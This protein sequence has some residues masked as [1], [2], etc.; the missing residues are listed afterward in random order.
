MSVYYSGGRRHTVIVCFRFAPSCLRVKPLHCGFTH[1]GCVFSFESLSH[2]WDLGGEETT[3]RSLFS[4]VRVPRGF[5]APSAIGGVN[6]VCRTL[7]RGR[8]CE[9]LVNCGNVCG[10]VDRLFTL[11]FCK[12]SGSGNSLCACMCVRECIL[13]CARLLCELPALYIRGLELNNV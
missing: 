6:V 2:G 8:F 3:T 7:Y 10:A 1:L 13:V 9:C 5:V 4:Q 12:P 11:F